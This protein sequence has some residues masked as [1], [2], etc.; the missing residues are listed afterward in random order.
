MKY[1]IFVGILMGAISIMIYTNNT[2][3]QKQAS[4]EISQLAQTMDQFQN[5]IRSKDAQLRAI[6]MELQNLKERPRIQ[7]PEEI[8][9]DN[10]VK[11]EEPE[12]TEDERFKRVVEENKDSALLI[13]RRMQSESRSDWSA[14]AEEKIAFEF[15][16]YELE[17]TNVVSVDCGETVCKVEVE[18]GERS[19]IVR[20]VGKA[21]DNPPFEI[22]SVFVPLPPDG[23]DSSTSTVYYSRGESEPLL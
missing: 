23:I 22:S 1:V 12:L 19:N 10:A 13:D 11:E 3:S 2:D 7:A 6:G 5:E 20:F 16:N 17:D 8:Q 18:H 14:E 4:A 21:M 15:A 9:K